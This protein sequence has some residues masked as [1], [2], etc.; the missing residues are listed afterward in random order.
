MLYSTSPSLSIQKG[1]RA[2]PSQI[3]PQSSDLLMLPLGGPLFGKEPA[4]IVE[5]I[6]LVGGDVLTP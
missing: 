3:L 1:K 5:A 4:L 6:F 2:E